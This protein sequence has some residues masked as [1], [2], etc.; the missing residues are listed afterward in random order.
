[1]AG[2]KSSSIDTISP[3]SINRLR[4]EISKL[5]QEHKAKEDKWEEQ[6]VL[7]KQSWKMQVQQLEDRLSGQKEELEQ[8]S[9]QLEESKREALDKMLELEHANHQIAQ[10]EDELVATQ[11]ERDGL[12]MTLAELTEQHDVQKRRSENMDDRLGSLS[13]SLQSMMADQLKVVTAMRDR[14][15]AI[16]RVAKVRI[17]LLRDMLKQEEE[18][19]S[20]FGNNEDLQ[21]AVDKQ[22]REM[23]A[24]A[25]VIAAARQ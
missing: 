6:L 13:A 5:K 2:T 23:D 18:L 7:S 25:A 10:L 15:G 12:R 9:N 11:E 21:K 22:S 17:E 16:Q 4:T 1:M 24:I 19:D 20:R 8:L 14:D 3:R